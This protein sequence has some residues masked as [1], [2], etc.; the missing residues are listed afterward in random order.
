MVNKVVYNNSKQP[1][2]HLGDKL[3][4]SLVLMISPGKNSESDKFP[5]RNGLTPTRQRT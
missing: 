4:K 5:V 1:F 2:F 3:T